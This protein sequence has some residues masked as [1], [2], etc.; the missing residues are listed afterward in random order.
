VF[1]ARRPREL[2]AAV[3]INQRLGTPFGHSLAKNRDMCSGTDVGRRQAVRNA[4]N[5]FKLITETASRVINADQ[6][7]HQFIAGFL[8]TE[9]LRAFVPRTRKVLRSSADVSNFTRAKAR[10]IHK[11]VFV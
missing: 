9:V 2:A 1:A 5:T 11:L 7:K 8:F 4:T 6:S 3:L 10:D